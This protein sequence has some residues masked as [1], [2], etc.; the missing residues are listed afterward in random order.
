[1]SAKPFL[2]DLLGAAVI[3][4]AIWAVVWGFAR[5][6]PETGISESSA[7]WA[8][9]ISLMLGFCVLAGRRLSR[10]AK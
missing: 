2:K 6:H 8:A 10:S 7:V 1:M 5:T 4:L 3:A 9:G